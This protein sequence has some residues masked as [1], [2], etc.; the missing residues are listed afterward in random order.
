MSD[1]VEQVKWM[2]AETSSDTCVSWKSIDNKEC[3]WD[4]LDGDWYGSMRRQYWCL[5]RVW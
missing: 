1:S 4:E 5:T 2:I 3:Q